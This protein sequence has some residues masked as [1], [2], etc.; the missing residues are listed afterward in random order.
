MQFKTIK[1]FY[2]DLFVEQLQEA[3][4]IQEIAKNIKDQTNFGVNIQIYD[5]EYPGYISVY[6]C[7]VLSGSDTEDN[8]THFV[9]YK[10]EE[11]YNNTTPII[12]LPLE[13]TGYPYIDKVI[14]DILDILYDLKINVIM[15]NE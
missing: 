5:P 8:L 13:D 7:V 9:V 4:V 3:K 15:D 14:Y 10:S 6:C 12:N 1:T 11:D 2:E